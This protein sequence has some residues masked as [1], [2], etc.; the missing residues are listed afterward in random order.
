MDTSDPGHIARQ[1][2]PI[3]MVR[4][5]I[6]QLTALRTTRVQLY[7]GGEPLVHP[8][9]DEILEMFAD[10]GIYIQ[11]LTNGTLLNRRIRTKLRQLHA[12]VPFIR[13]SVHGVS[14]SS[15]LHAT[16]SDQFERL[17]DNIVSLAGELRDLT[18][19]PALGLFIPTVEEFDSA[20]VDQ[21][22]AFAEH[23]GVDFVWFAEDRR[24][25]WPTRE[26]QS[27]FPRLRDF[28]R[29]QA[30]KHP[31]LSVNYTTSFT[32]PYQRDVCYQEITQMHLTYDPASGRLLLVRCPNF[33]PSGLM[34]RPPE[35]AYLPVTPASLYD[36]W[37][38]YLHTHTSAHKPLICSERNRCMSYRRNERLGQRRDRQ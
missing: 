11:L 7:G 15:F 31:T 26:D 30:G 28:V 2:V 18:E 17:Q 21:F 37:T 23:A 9:I 35:G 38:S 24:F 22:L 27:N 19:R 12:F 8:R 14:R 6:P 4:E 20:E 34:D 1:T 5:L 33:Y 29:K 13:I 10:A 3:E 36:Q 25:P 32:R 16:G